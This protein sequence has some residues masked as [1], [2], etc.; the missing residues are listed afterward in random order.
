MSVINNYKYQ[1]EITSVAGR[2]LGDLLLPAPNFSAALQWSFLRGLHEGRSFRYSHPE[3]ATV[4]PVWDAGAG[5]PFV[6]HIRVILTGDEDQPYSCDIPVIG[7]FSSAVQKA[8]ATMVESGTLDVGE[9][10]NYK[11]CAVRD[12]QSATSLVNRRGNGQQFT[13][14]DD[15]VGEPVANPFT[16]DMK[17]MAPLLSASDRCGGSAWHDGD[18]PVYLPSRVLDELIGLA[19]GVEEVETGA[20]LVGNVFRDPGGGLFTEVA[21]QIPARH[22]IAE[23][24]SLTFTAETWAAV[25]AAIKLRGCGERIVG[26]AH[27]HPFFCRACP[28]ERRRA[29]PLGSPMFSD[30]DR[31]VH[32]TVFGQAHQLAFLLSFLGGGQ[33]SVDLFSWREGLITARGFYVC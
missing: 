9:L 26:W 22:T 23:R 10:F 2:V 21:A 17:E 16:I 19:E 30:A 3:T 15:F 7:Y 6:S 18:L 29:C 32:R 11:V 20:I 8:S 14:V 4:E 5:Q 33:P 28:A 24:A 27:S 25:D 31:S 12:L 13:D 1:A